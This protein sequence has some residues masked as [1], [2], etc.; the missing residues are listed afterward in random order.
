MFTLSVQPDDVTLT[1]VQDTST[2]R[3]LRRPPRYAGAPQLWRP[4]MLAGSWD[5]SSYSLIASSGMIVMRSHFAQA[6]HLTPYSIAPRVRNSLTNP[7][8]HPSPLPS[9]SRSC[10]AL[11]LAPWAWGTGDRVACYDRDSCYILKTIITLNL[12]PWYHFTF[13]RTCLPVHVQYR[14]LV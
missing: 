9:S 5:A 1:A 11:A 4:G 6:A 2:N 13:T 8:N 14:I 10:L 12:V 7:V 3:T